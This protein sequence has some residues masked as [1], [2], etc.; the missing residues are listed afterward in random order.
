VEMEPGS[1]HDCDGIFE[2]E[3]AEKLTEPVLYHFNILYDQTWDYKKICDR[4]FE[5]SKPYL[6]DLEHVNQPN[7]HVHFQGYSSSVHNTV[8]AKIT[9]LVAKHHLR[10]LNPKCRPS[11][12]SCRPVDV[13]R[14]QYLAKELK[15]EYVL[16]SNLFTPEELAELKEKSVLHCTKLKTCVKEFIA[17]M[18]PEKLKKMLEA[19]K[20]VNQL[21][22]NAGWVLV[23]AAEDKLIEL[24]EYNKHHTRCSVIRGLMAHP[25]LP[26]QWKGKLYVS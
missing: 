17:A 6:C 13:T 18:K 20:D 8:K 21:V 2:P 5:K 4:F 15:K 16:A 26:T 9:R 25:D 3:D 12:M 10:T 24:P 14:F 19:S 7:T 23:K 22:D 11:S 1:P